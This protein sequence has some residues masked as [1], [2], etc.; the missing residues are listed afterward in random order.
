MADIEDI[1][2]SAWNKDA[3]ALKP[4]LDAVMAAKVSEKM[5]GIVADVASKMFNNSVDDPDEPDVFSG[6]DNLQDDD[7]EMGQEEL[8]TNETD[9]EGSQEDADEYETDN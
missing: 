7:S 1:L 8:E 9:Y 5:D 2:V 4:A 3:V 6:N